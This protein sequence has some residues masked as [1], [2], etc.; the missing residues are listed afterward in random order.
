MWRGWVDPRFLYLGTSWRWVSASRPG[1]FTPGERAPDTH[2]TDVGWT[3][4]PVWTMKR[5]KYYFNL[6]G[7]E[8]QPLGRLPHGQSLYRLRY[9]SFNQDSI[10]ALVRRA[11][12]EPQRIDVASARTRSRHLPVASLDHYESAM[13]R[14][15]SGSQQSLR[16]ILE[17]TES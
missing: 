12:E 5:N 6:L 14:W 11:W 15:I 2:Y 7:L 17:T 16:F 13:S 9:P 8:L 3:P 1:R 10:P 4:E